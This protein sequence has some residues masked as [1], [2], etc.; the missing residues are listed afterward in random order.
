MATAEQMVSAVLEQTNK[1]YVV[2][3]GTSEDGT[4]R[5]TR[6][7]DGY[8]FMEG[9]VPITGNGI[10]NLTFPIAFSGTNYSFVS[11]SEGTGSSTSVLGTKVDNR[12]KTEQG[13]RVVITYNNGGSE[14]GYGS[15]GIPF[16]FIACGY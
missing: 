2:E 4:I 8:I 6:Y 11:T 15:N 12:Y 16:N 7:S 3:T 1:R 14:N 13:I 10:V 5:Y 9:N